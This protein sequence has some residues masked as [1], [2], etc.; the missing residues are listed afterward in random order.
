MRLITGRA[1][2]ELCLLA[3]LILAGKGAGAANA[4]PLSVPFGPD[5]IGYDGAF[6]PVQIRAGTPEQYLLVFPST[7]SAET[8]VTG[9]TLCDG[10]TCASLRGGIFYTSNS[11]TWQPLGQYELGYSALFETTSQ[12]QYGFDSLALTDTVSA[13]NQ[14]FAVVDDELHWNGQLGLNVQETRFNNNTNYFSLISTLVQNS[15]VVPSHSYGYTAG[16]SYQGKGVQGSL[17]LGGVDTSR[18]T[19]S[20]VWFT[21]AP[22]YI[23]SL[24]IRSLFLNAS[25]SSANWTSNP[26]QVMSRSDAA[27]FVIDT[28]T[29]Y[30]WLPES[31]CDRIAEALNLTW[32]PSL[33]LYTY[34][35]TTTPQDLA[36][37]DLELIFNVA[38]SPELTTTSI[39]LRLSYSALNLQLS[40]PYP[41]LFTTYNETR[42][43]YFPLRRANSTQQYTI[44]RA[45]LQEN[46][47]TVDYE[48]NVFSL[49]RALFPDSS[50]Q[51]QLATIT[52]PKGSTWPG[53]PGSSGLSGGAKAG[54]SIAGLFTAIVSVALI[55]WYCF[56]RR[57]QKRGSVD[58]KSQRARLL[59]MFSRKST[60]KSSMSGTNSA[61]ELT[62]DKY[63][64]TEM[65]S[66]VTNSRFELSSTTPAEMPAADVAPN[67]FQERTNARISQRNDPRSPIEL[68]EPQSMSSLSKTGIEDDMKELSAPSAPAYS[69]TE[70][71]E[72]HSASVSPYSRRH[73]TNPFQRGSDNGISP[74]SGSNTNSDR[75]RLSNAHHSM[76]GSN[77][78]RF[79]DPISPLPAGRGHG[80]S[81]LMASARKGTQRPGSGSN[82][83]R[84]SGT[85]SSNLSNRN[86]SRRSPSRDSRFREELVENPTTQNL[87]AG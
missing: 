1:H 79:L 33:E 29:P 26:L 86:E 22:G 14:I 66:D 45:F 10:P 38:E 19:P 65:V 20:D 17:T 46:Y 15:S 76:S 57:D 61:A 77:S 43:D 56:R 11:T 28:S 74:V 42:V 84:D 18:F 6:S 54:V 81:S 8:W 87:R 58:E 27:A 9:Q 80:S 25:S 36:A 59:S 72:R 70:I 60:Q 53:P 31:V 35:I 52:R 71:N 68:T 13:S 62:A 30:F 83:D 51:P 55:W 32:N 37:R 39:D 24:F 21:L 73:S 67:F 85:L 50:Q 63:H 48:R 4:G 49:S 41:G 44:G 64:P 5:Y 2:P 69:P 40:Y 47:L 23:P 75:D 3:T 16:A 12:G 7:T 82:D 78:S 34:D